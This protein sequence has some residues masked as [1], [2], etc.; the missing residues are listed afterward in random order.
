M[1]RAVLKQFEDFKVHVN[2]MFKNVYRF[3]LKI[4][5]LPIF[6]KNDNMIVRRKKEKGPPQFS[7]QVSFFENS[8]FSMC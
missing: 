1:R 8:C 3:F 6:F 7:V 5:L 4:D 2:V